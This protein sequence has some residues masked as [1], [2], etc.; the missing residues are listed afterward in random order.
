MA[1]PGVA[2][3]CGPWPA[4]S[5][6]HLS[7]PQGQRIRAAGLGRAQER[8]VT[9]PHARRPVSV[10]LGDLAPVCAVPSHPVPSLLP[11]VLSF[12]PLDLLCSTGHTQ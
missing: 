8:R 11:A 6:F 12:S 3:R 2:W 5:I 4:H 10:E 1:G 7:G 9:K